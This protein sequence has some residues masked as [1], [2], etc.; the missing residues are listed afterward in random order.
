MDTCLIAALSGERNM[1]GFQNNEDIHKS[2]ASKFNV[3]LEV[4]RE[5]L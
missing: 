1:V 4:T 2:T 3:P 5:R